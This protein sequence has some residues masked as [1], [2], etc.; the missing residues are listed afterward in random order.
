L[1]GIFKLVKGVLLLAAGIGA[2]SLLRHDVQM[3]ISRWIDTLEIEQRPHIVRH[4]LVK[5]GLIDHRNLVFASAFAFFYASL[6]LTEGVGLILRK[7]WA[8]YLT[9]IATSSFLPI[10]I[11][12]IW[13]KASG[14]RLLL[15]AA[16]LFIVGYL[17]SQLKHSKKS[18]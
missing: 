10:E 11:Y 16:N 2:L 4:L 6:L 5:A 3:M 14:P 9:I 7:R 15:L 1:I 8:E 13:R 12:E 18:A 17:I